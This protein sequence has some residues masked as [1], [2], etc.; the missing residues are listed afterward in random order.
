MESTAVVSTHLRQYGTS[1]ILPDFEARGGPVD[2]GLTVPMT[3]H[4]KGFNG[5]NDH[6]KVN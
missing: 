5:S 2:K 4:V 6:V 1:V 3:Y